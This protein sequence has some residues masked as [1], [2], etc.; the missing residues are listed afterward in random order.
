M[1]V[2]NR[3]N[4]SSKLVCLSWAG[5]S[6]NLGPVRLKCDVCLGLELWHRHAREKDA[7]VGGFRLLRGFLTNRALEGSLDGLESVVYVVLLSVRVLTIYKC[8][9]DDRLVCYPAG[10]IESRITFVCYLIDPVVLIPGLARLVHLSLGDLHDRHHLVCI[11]GP[12]V[13][14]HDPGDGGRAEKVDMAE[15]GE[16]LGNLFVDL[17]GGYD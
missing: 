8:V 5:Q 2:C 6:A 3:Y 11:V 7:H 10:G 13:Y 1:A 9:L 15:V 14:H 16:D 17:G 12:R 4:S